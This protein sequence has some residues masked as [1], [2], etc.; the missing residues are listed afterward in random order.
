MA[1]QAL[2]QEPPDFSLVLGGP[3]Y[4][5]FRR[6]HL[7]GPAL[8]LLRRR[9]L[10]FVLLCWLPLA[11]LAGVGGDFIGGPKFSF[12]HDVEPHVRFL[13]SLP[14]LFLAEITVH[15]RLRSAVRSFIDRRIVS[16]EDLP[17]FD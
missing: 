10:F 14:V 16:P 7:T 17:R 5:L 13:I 15:R 12:I 3:L 2:Q 11:I 8:E 1:V 4:Q 9:T 6:T